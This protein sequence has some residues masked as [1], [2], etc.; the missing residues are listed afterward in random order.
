[1]NNAI[2]YKS[3]LL[4]A[5]NTLCTVCS[6]LGASLLHT[7]VKAV[8]ESGSSL[9]FTIMGALHERSNCDRP[10]FLCVLITTSQF[11]S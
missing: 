4:S 2:A 11:L 8:K 6:S 5:V 7:T 10:I 3:A 9:Q 1:V